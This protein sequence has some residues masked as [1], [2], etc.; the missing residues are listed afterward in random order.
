M[1]R[2]FTDSELREVETKTSYYNQLSQ[3]ASEN[4]NCYIKLYSERNGINI[5][6]G[7]LPDCI[8]KD[9]EYIRLRDKFRFLFSESRLLN[10]L[11]AKQLKEL[12][13]IKRQ[14]LTTTFQRTE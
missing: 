12:H 6:S 1:K 2:K 7:L 13:E 3:K 14:N 5:K 9:S 8:T 4:L 10:K 11:Y